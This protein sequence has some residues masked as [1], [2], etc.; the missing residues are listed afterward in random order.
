[1][2]DVPTLIDG[3]LCLRP[4]RADD[5]PTLAR[6]ANDERVSRGLRDRFPFPYTL[7]DAKAFL[8]TCVALDGEWRFA[9]IADDALIG[10][11]GVRR[12]VDI[13]AR[14]AELGYWLAPSH[15]GRGLM[16]RAVRLAVPEAMRAFGL[17][18][19]HASVFANNPASMRV[20]EKAGFAR[21]GTQACAVVKR[22]ELLDTV[23]YALTRRSLD[24]AL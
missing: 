2:C 15:W 22:G 9:V 11:L 8:E 20:L 4:W 6:I 10:G 24:A 19:V 23:T 13:Y 1:M 3:E 17:Y 7:D 12:G 5:A 21:E 18:R 16:A 14:A